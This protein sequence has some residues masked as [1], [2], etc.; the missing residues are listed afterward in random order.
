[1]KT[2]ISK[3]KKKKKEKLLRIISREDLQKTY[4]NKN[5]ST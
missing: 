4:W 1:M 3:I 5:F 2:S